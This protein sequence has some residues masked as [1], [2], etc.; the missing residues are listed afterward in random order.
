M[1]L[2]GGG[3]GVVGLWWDLKCGWELENCTIVVEPDCL[4]PL[5]TTHVKMSPL[6]LP[7]RCCD[8]H[9]HAVSGL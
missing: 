9:L 3:R 4:S 2:S 7:R 6:V 8:D 1:Q 5:A